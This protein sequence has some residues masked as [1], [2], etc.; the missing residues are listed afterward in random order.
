MKLTGNRLFTNISDTGKAFLIIL[1]S[2]IF[3]G[4][5]QIQ[6]S[7]YDMQWFF[8]LFNVGCSAKIQS[9]YISM[10]LEGFF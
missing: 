7:A 9:S 2:D 3:L 6:L 1:L 10:A 4:Y 5:E 8:S